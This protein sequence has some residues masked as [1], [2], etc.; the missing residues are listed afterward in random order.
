MTESQNDRPDQHDRPDYRLSG[1]TRE[2]LSLLAEGLSDREIAERLVMTINTIKWYN[3][4]IY[5]IL[6]VGSRTQA[7]ARAQELNLL[8]QHVSEPHVLEDSGIRDD[9]KNVSV[10]TLSLPAETTPFIGRRREADAIGRILDGTNTIASTHL[11]TLVGPPGTGKTR[12]AL[13][14]AREMVGQ[15]HDGIY[16]VMLASVT[17]PAQVM[18]A[19]ANAI[20]VNETHSQPLIETVQHVLRD[21]QVMLVLDNFEHLLPAAMEISALLAALPQ[22][23]VLATSREPLRLY[24][25]WEYLV[26]PMELP[27]ATLTDMHSLAICESV[28]LFVQRA[29]AVRSDFELNEHNAADIAK[30]CVRLEGLPLAIELAAARIKLLT[31]QTLLA[32]LSRR[33]EILTGGAQDLPVRQRTLR[34]TIEWSYDLLSAEEKQVFHRLA[35]FRGGRSLEAIESVCGPGLEMDS[36]DGV[37]SLLNKSLLFQR[38]GVDGEP[39][40]VML[41]TLHEYAW[42]QLEASGEAEMMRQRHAA[43]YVDLAERSEPQLRQSGFAYWMARLDAENDNLRA[44]LEWA[45]GGTQKSG[46]DPVLGAR[47]AAALRDYWMMSGQFT[48]GILWTRRALHHAEALRPEVHARLLI[49]AGVLLFFWVQ[50]DEEASGQQ[51][52]AQAEALARETG[53]QMTLA[54]ALSYLAASSIG[55]AA[56][57]T[58]ALARAEE[59]LTIFR[60]LGY[61]PGMAQALNIIGELTRIQGDDQRAQAVYEECLLLVRETGE[62]RRESM[63]LSNLGFIAEHQ[64]DVQLAWQ[65]FHEALEKMSDFRYDKHLIVSS[66]VAMAATIAV[67]GDPK[68]AA[69]LI[70]AADAWLELMGVGLQPGNRPEHER[71]LVIIRSQLDDVT[72]KACWHEGRGMSLEAMVAAALEQHEHRRTEG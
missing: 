2:I 35:V 61:R 1:R 34:N 60:T 27:D 14:V 56:E 43:C 53:D 33:L 10:G 38:E 46:V 70:G 62:T 4:Q 31:P 22:L 32:R 42:E 65:R 64:G 63:I 69:R 7:I 11:L 29:Q 59:G 21:R 25:E 15:F 51:A 17:D 55:I 12:L 9:R 44:A 67:Q 37:E 13:Q 23:T 6:G 39:Y 3:R 66:V 52:L 50:A 72:F 68:R 57:Y 26:P 36:L 40:F 54:W 41:E 24:G 47:L 58:Q 18:Q 30:I 5:S 48:D 71:S 45:L 8:E 28:A 16:F 49:T 20:G 19:I